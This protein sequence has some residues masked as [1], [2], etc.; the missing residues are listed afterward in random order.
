M[1]NLSS[2]E[3]ENSKK[4][5]CSDPVEIWKDV[6]HHI[7]R[8]YYQVSN[9]GR[10]KTKGRHVTRGGPA[11]KYTYW[12][13]ERIVSVRR[14]K[15][16]PHLFCSLYATKVLNSNKTAYLHKLVAESFIKRPSKK[17]VFVT[18]IDGNYE[19]NM[20]TNLKW[21]TASE[22]SKR[23]IE[24]YPENKTKLKEHNEKVGYYENLRHPAWGEENKIKIKYMVRWGVSIEEISRIFKCSSATVYKIVKTIK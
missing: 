19:N 12:L 18:H 9:L 15:E 24:K 21:I 10:I 7:F 22:N 16:N 6:N 20:V 11:N 4:I 8:K 2:T 3:M 23:N 14:S 17:H 1:E 13:N 5:L